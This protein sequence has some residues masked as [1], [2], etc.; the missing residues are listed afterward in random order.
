MLCKASQFCRFCR[1]CHSSFAVD[2]YLI[3]INVNVV[4]TR[5]F[6]AGITYLESLPLHKVHRNIFTMNVPALWNRNYFLRFRFWL[7]KS[8]S[9][10]SDFWKVII[11][12][13]TFKKLRFRFRLLKSYGPVPTFEK[14]RFQLH[15]KTIKSKFLKQ[16]IGIFFAFLHSK[17]FYKEK[18]YKF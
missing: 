9:S 7:L 2:T 12:V 6:W 3:I 4:V 15:I 17:L 14:L 10:G 11:P 8:Y 18:V 16:N 5:L 1:K 13:P